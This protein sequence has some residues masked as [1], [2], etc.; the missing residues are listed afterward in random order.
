MKKVNIGF[1]DEQTKSFERVTNSDEILTWLN[2]QRNFFEVIDEVEGT[3]IYKVSDV[4]Y[5]SIK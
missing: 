5:I 4:D 1:V 3:F 2:S